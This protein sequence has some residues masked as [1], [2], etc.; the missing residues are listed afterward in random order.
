MKEAY[1]GADRHNWTKAEL[2]DYERA[3]IK[4]RDEI[5]RVELAEKRAIRDVAKNLKNNGVS[6]EVIS[7]STGL[8]IEE[9][10]EF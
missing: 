10:E 5:G 7:K 3:N 9:I 1:L 8:S 4:I 2:A 6:Y